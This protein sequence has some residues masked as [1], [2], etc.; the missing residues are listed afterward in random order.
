MTIKAFRI[1]K[2]CIATDA[3]LDRSLLGFQPVPVSPAAYRFAAETFRRKLFAAW[4][5]DC[6]KVMDECYG[7][8]TARK[9]GQPWLWVL[10][11]PFTSRSEPWNLPWINRQP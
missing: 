4:P 8:L 7:I 6:T 5:V 3:S 11:V 2:S 10:Y 1:S 9:H